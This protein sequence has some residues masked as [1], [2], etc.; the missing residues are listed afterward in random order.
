MSLLT[1]RFGLLSVVATPVAV[2]ITLLHNFIWHERFTWSDL[3]AQRSGPLADRLWRWHAANGL[4]SLGGNTILMH[5]L[6]E[7]LKAPATPAAIGAILLCS[8]A[9]FLVANG[10]VY[11]PRK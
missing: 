9:N 1:K 6:V 2:E 10:W 7:Q 3:R 5:C 11:A 4:I 8:A